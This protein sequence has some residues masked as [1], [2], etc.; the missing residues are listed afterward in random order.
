MWINIGAHKWLWFDGYGRFSLGTAKAMIRAG[1][2]IY[3]FELETLDR[4]A[5]YLRAQGLDFSHATIQ[6]APPPNFR[7]LPGRSVAWT[8]HESTALPKGWAEHIN[9]KN[10]VCLVPSPWLIPVLIESGVKIPIEVVP[11]GID[12]D[13]CEVLPTRWNQPFTIGCTADRGNRKG[14]DLVW[15]AFYKAFEHTNTDVRLLIKCR[16]GSL[17]RLDFS[18]SSDTRMTVWRADVEAV[19]DVFSQMDVF[20][21]PN[22]CEGYGMIPREAAACGVPTVTT[23]WSGTADDCDKWAVPLEQY[24]L[25]ESDM[26]DCGGKWAEPDLDE[27]IWR[28]RDMYAH[29]DEYKAR[30]LT[31]AQWMRDNA[32]YSHAADK[33][34]N[35]LG[36][37][38]GGP[39]PVEKP[40]VA[41][42]PSA[43]GHGEKL[44]V[45][46]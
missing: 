45:A 33:L 7:H 46:Q 18:Y 24:K 40:A 17:S 11:G 21:N 4:P 12:P 10:Q 27:I 1:H 14:Y 3:P 20:F 36:K 39:P 2:R 34:V 35:V 44:A 19:T 42:R 28:M 16:P 26:L 38:L 13:E 30:A 31:A 22:R 9:T 29:Q 43:N 41:I 32:T 25:V 23:R 6:L 37:W 15:T 8:M 5:W